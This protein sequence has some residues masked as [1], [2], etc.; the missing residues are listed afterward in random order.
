MDIMSFDKK[1]DEVASNPGT[2]IEIDEYIFRYWLDLGLKLRR[3]DSKFA[4]LDFGMRVWN[5]R[6]DE[7]FYYH[8]YKD[9]QKGVKTKYFASLKQLEKK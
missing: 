3:F 9:E 8:F 4:I 2:L 7:Y 5:D 1:M 6:H